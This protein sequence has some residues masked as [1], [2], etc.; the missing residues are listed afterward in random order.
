[1]RIGPP[2]VNL[3][4]ADIYKLVNRLVARENDPFESEHVTC[5]YK[6]DLLKLLWFL[7]DTIKKC[8]TYSTESKWYQ[9]RTMELLKRK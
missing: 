6:H 5:N 3:D 2:D 4:V 9:E 8:S 7:E 1:M